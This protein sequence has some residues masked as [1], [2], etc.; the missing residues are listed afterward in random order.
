MKLNA[1]AFGLAVGVVLG[2]VSFVATLFS[3]WFGA[4]QTITVLAAAY[5][6]YSWSILGAFIGLVWGVIYG[7][8]TGWLVATV[9]NGM[10][11]KGSAG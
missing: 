5:F 9:Y 8:V 6:G 1:N 10:A 3:L 4:G 2:L 11:G 7:F